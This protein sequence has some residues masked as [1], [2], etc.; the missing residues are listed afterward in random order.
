MRFER[1]LVTPE[2]AANWLKANAD[3]QRNRKTSK[4]PMYA[5]DMLAGRWNS[6]TG[7]TIKISAKGRLLDGQNRLEAVV[8]SGA[9]IWFDVAF[10]VPDAAMLVIDTGAARTAADTLKIG[11]ATARFVSGAIVRWAINWDVRNFMNLRGG[12]GVI[13]TH[14]EIWDRYQSE[15]GMFDAAAQRAADLR[16]QGIGTA[17]STG[18]AFYLFSKIDRDEAHTFFD[19]LITGADLSEGNPVLTLRNRFVRSKVDRLR[20]EEQLSMSVRAWNAWRASELL[21][22]VQVTGREPLSNVNFPQPK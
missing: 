19:Q 18:M 14:T 16:A 17:S 21:Y 10:D 2:K 9:P 6:E 22:R 11:G 15:Q 12:I 8:L 5:R 13:P 4:I 7:E 3:N 1:V 20:V